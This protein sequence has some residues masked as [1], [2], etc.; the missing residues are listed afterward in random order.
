MNTADQEF[1]NALSKE[2]RLSPGSISALEVQ[3]PDMLDSY[4]EEATRRSQ[5]KVLVKT[6][7]DEIEVPQS[8]LK[9]TTTHPLQILVLLK[10]KYKDEWVEWLPETLWESIRRDIGPLSEVSKNKIQ[11]LALSLAT[12]VPWQDWTT[13]ENCGRSFNDSIPVFGQIQPLSPAETAY[14]ITLL[15]V[16]NDYPFSD[17]V[18]G[19]IASVCLYNG[20]VYAPPEWFDGAQEFVD[21][22]AKSSGLKNKIKS[23][24]KKVSKRPL[25][26]VEF[27]VEN[28]VDVQIAKLW[29]VQEYLRDKE[30]RLKEN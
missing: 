20:I 26:D 5:P 21:K 19:Y 1:F 7:K 30:S 15:K 22:Q 10:E 28:P 24:W 16:I 27:D 23:A 18:L 3:Q 25:V 4:E 13:F 14:T 29:A 2:G 11:A 9:R 17:E 6:E 8:F 12:N